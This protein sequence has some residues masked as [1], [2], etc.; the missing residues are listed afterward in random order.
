MAQPFFTDTDGTVHLLE[1]QVAQMCR[2]VV[3]LAP[4]MRRMPKGELMI[5]WNADRVEAMCGE[6]LSVK[7]LGSMT[8]V[9]VVG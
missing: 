5:R 7:T 3:A 1:P 6:W 9:T 2:V 8:T 4:R